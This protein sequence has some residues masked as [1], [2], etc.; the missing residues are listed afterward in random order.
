MHSDTFWG[1]GGGRSKARGLYFLGT[2]AETYQQPPR[3]TADSH[4]ALIVWVQQIRTFSGAGESDE[5]AAELR[6]DPLDCVRH[7]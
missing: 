3:E 7:A 6:K 2:A 4:R 1:A 5:Q